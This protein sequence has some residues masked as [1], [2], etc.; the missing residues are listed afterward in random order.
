MNIFVGGI[1]YLGSDIEEREKFSFTN[2]KKAEIY[3]K[4]SNIDYIKG[5]VIL[6]TCNRMEVYFSLEDGIRKNPFEV[7]CSLIGAD[8]EIH[9]EHSKQYENENAFEHLCML[10]C[11]ALSQIF[12]ED[13]IITQV[14]TSIEFARECDMTDSFI[15]VFFRSA[16]ACAKKIRTE[17]NLAQ[18]DIS[19]SDKVIEKII[20][21]N[22]P[23]KNVLVI[24]NGEMGRRVAT[25]LRKKGFF[26][27]MTARQYRHGGLVIPKG[28]EVIN[29]EDRYKAISNFDAVVSATLSPHFTITKECIEKIE[30]K[31]EYYFDLA[32]PR[33]IESS[34]KDIKGLNVY[35]VDEISD[36]KNS[37]RHLEQI[38]AMKK[39]I[40]KYRGDLEKWESYKKAITV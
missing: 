2:S 3:D 1:D 22:M 19:I 7:I 39:Y 4:L 26:V 25:D 37:D 11:G 38:L 16:V 24:G 12:G 32:I 20:N 30:K 40:D 9:K 23:I 27:T 29:Y 31:P 6:S 35:N 28:V 15:E 33:D 21:E 18:R 36:Y 17:I 34:I 5:A 8:Y 10:S 14:K 13:Q